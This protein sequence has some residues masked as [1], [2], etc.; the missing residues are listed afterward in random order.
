[1]EEVVKVFFECV[2]VMEDIIFN[3][4]VVLGEC[5]EDIEVYN[6]ILCIG[7]EFILMG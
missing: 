5:N 2:Y 7:D 1:M 4:K 3:V 6:I